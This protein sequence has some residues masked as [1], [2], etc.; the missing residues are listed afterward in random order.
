[1]LAVRLVQL[2]SRLGAIAPVCPSLFVH[3][4]DTL[5]DWIEQTPR[6]QALSSYVS[7]LDSA[8]TAPHQAI[9]H[10]NRLAV[11]AVPF[12]VLV[13]RDEKEERVRQWDQQH[14]VESRFGARV[15]SR[16][17]SRVGS[18]VGQEGR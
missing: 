8:C 18:R 12:G 10:D 9:R 1:M 7:Q 6:R 3:L 14:P 17:G 5:A 11:A 15:C 13:E 4:F 16:A 2:V